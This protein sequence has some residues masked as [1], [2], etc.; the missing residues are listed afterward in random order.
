MLRGMAPRVSIITPAYNVAPFIGTALR[1]LL[2]QTMR[3]WEAVVVDDGSTDA[4]A[5]TVAVFPDSRIRL[6]RQD[7]AGVSAARG[8]AMAAA[9]GDCLLFLDADDWLAPDALERLLAALDAEP[10]AV[11]A[12]GPFAF[13]AED[14]VPGDTPLR[15]KSGPFPSGD[16][17]AALLRENLLANGGHL[18]V[19]RGAMARC[20]G[21]RAHI[22]YG[23]DW[24]CWI[25]LALLGPFATVPGP[26]PLLFVRQRRGSAYFRM[27]H[28]PAAFMPAMEAIFSNPDLIARL[29][30]A[31]VAAL[32][33]QAEAENAW[34]IG[35]EL[36]RHGRRGD[37][38]PWLRRSLRAAPS[39]KRAL[40]LA[41]A[42]ALPL[43]PPSLHG[44]FAPYPGQ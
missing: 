2:A 26:A 12:Y 42:E 19:R 28:D 24:E 39:A 6:I 9:S 5:E 27:A 33:V 21:F 44:P 4:T 11:A 31:R 1:S 22:R 37:G 30:A 36:I 15:V 3:D 29:G 7:N 38:L 17:V 23:E 10:D 13:V 16:V 25:R 8:R 14:A 43:L 34:I 20:G 35:R 41:A 32:R 40:L 18:L